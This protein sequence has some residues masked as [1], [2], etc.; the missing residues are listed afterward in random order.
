MA[1]KVIPINSL[2]AVEIAGKRVLVRV[3]HNVPL[4]NDGGIRD[5]ERIVRSLGT[6]REI[7]SR[8][9]RVLILSHLGYPDG[10]YIPELST[11][12]L[13]DRLGKLM[14]IRVLHHAGLSLELA[15]K[16]AWRVVP[17]EIL[18][19]ENTR[20]WAGEQAD[21]AELASC[22]ATCGDLYINE[23]FSASHRHHASIHCLAG[24]LPAFSGRQ[25]ERERRQL[26][27]FRRNDERRGIVLG[28]AKL[29]H[30]LKAVSQLDGELAVL[31]LGGMTA[32]AVTHFLGM[33]TGNAEFTTSCMGV[34]ER[35]WKTLLARKIVPL[36]PLDWVVRDGS[37]RLRLVDQH[38]VA[39]SDAII[40]VGPQTVQRFLAQLATVRSVFWNGPLGVYESSPGEEGSLG[41]ATGLVRRKQCGA[42]IVVGGGDTLALIA[43]AGLSKSFTF[44]SSGGGA[45]LEFIGR[46]DD[47]PGLVHLFRDQ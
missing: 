27:S 12:K 1:A 42:K 21:S 7:V 8:G 41:L 2:D 15:R 18:Y 30:K 10:Q 11:Q 46:G 34:V 31:C 23:A 24:L 45:T 19:L 5:D 36:L 47:L 3:D 28:G 16:A 13:A 20:F 14:G 4:T 26:L 9:A 38:D 44:C 25:L 43:A 32:I 39:V 35:A 29:N 37:G 33:P 17:G 6:L 40:D 22:W